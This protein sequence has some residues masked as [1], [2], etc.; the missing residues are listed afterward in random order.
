MA[1]DAHWVMNIA[2]SQESN[3]CEHLTWHTALRQPLHFISNRQ[4]SM[5]TSSLSA[6]ETLMEESQGGNGVLSRRVT[7]AAWFNGTVCQKAEQQPVSQQAEV[8]HIHA[9]GQKNTIEM[10]CEKTSFPSTSL[11]LSLPLS[12][13]HT[14]MHTHTDT[15]NQKAKAHVSKKALARAKTGGNEHR[16]ASS[17]FKEINS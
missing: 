10:D 4:F 2:S 9:H 15:Q 8:A 16:N 3:F 14:I 11:C 12:H 5:F 17:T 1:E 13:S 6:W 7:T